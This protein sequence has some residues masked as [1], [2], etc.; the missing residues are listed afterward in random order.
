MEL[1]HVEAF[2]TL[3]EELH[4][5]RAAARMHVTQARIS[6]LIR[7]LEREI[8]AVLF[9]RTSR[10]V[11]LT[12]PGERFRERAAPGYRQLHQALQDSRRDAREIG[13][14]LKIGYLPGMGEPV[15][16]VVSAF[17]ALHP[18]C[19]VMVSALGLPE[20]LL[21]YELLVSGKRDV[22]LTWAPDGGAAR[23]AGC[24]LTLGPVLAELPRALVV[25]DGHP[26]AARGSVSADELGRY[27]LLNLS[28]TVPQRVRDLWS[29]R[30][31]PS[32][33]PLRYTA[34]DVAT[35][36][37]RSELT[38]EDLMILVARGRGLYI[39]VDILLER[40]PFPGLVLLPIRGMAPKRVVPVWTT[41]AET[42]TVR[43]FAALAAAPADGAGAAAGGGR[44]VRGS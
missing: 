10:R 41:A 28:N 43:A 24:G 14:E 34:D 36:A 44:P 15:T 4:F 2:L 17:E 26:L 6:Q 1:R 16:R 29:P 37:G 32:G 23:A 25:P 9:E 13:G 5:R 33:E 3:A 42:P 35:M 39:T 11:R 8:G 22:A 40:F 31:T 19:E 20:A 27:E 30:A 21:P 38:A 7:E 18:G 12:G